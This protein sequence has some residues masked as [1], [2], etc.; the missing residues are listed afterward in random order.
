MR[1]LEKFFRNSFSNTDEFDNDGVIDP[2][3]S[4][5]NDPA[6]NSD[7]LMICLI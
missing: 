5:P 1:Q 7:V 3:D 4:D 6:S 2:L